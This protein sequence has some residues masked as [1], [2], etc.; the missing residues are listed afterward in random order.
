MKPDWKDAPEWARWLAMDADGTWY[1]YEFEP[2]RYAIFWDCLEGR[3][4]E[5]E[6]DHWKETLR[7]RPTSRKKGFLALFPCRDRKSVV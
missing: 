2:E 5:A 6:K 7:S 4:E 1:W 3:R